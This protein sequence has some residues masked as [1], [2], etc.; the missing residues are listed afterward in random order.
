MVDLT[1][2]YLR[3]KPEI[4]EAMQ[5]VLNRGD[6][7]NGAAVK[8]FSNALAGYLET[9]YVVPCANGTDAL[10][11]ALMALNLTRGDEVITSAF[12]FVS[13]VEV[14]VLLGLKPVFVD[15]DPDTYNIDTDAIRNALTERTRVV[16]PVHLFGQPAQ[17]DEIMEIALSHN[18][19]V[20]EDGAQSMGASCMVRGNQYKAG[21]VGH[22][23]C[24]SFFPTKNL[25]CFG[26]GGACFT[27]DEQLAGRLKMIM[28]HGARKKYFNEIIG[29]NSRLD[30]LQAAVLSEKLT[31]LD[32]FIDRRRSASRIY[33]EG[34]KDVSELN[35]PH[36]TEQ[37]THTFNQF[38]VRV[39]D[40]KRDELKQFL[41]HEGIPSMVYYPFP[42]HRQ[43]A[44]EVLSKGDLHL[45][46]SELACIEVL[47]LPMHTEM[48]EAQQEYII[49]RIKMFF[50]K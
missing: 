46:E 11:A 49:Q 3:L 26:D 48:T 38:T 27:N 5:Q 22:I 25:G 41:A 40:G 31:H 35:L 36:Q 14:I 29:M 44:F 20:V 7:I 39:L 37:S 9:D 43:P 4:D 12:S 32:D 34:L 28:N 50:G 21:T 6:Y 18:L 42:L 8:N 13:T 16:V 2:Q 15:I 1:G 19:Y 23:G 24:T 47:S 45:P 17:M 33:L 10:Q 30:T